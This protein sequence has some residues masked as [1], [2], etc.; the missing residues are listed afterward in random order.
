MIKTNMATDLLQVEAT[1]SELM[2]IQNTIKIGKAS[3]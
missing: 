3:L 2:H 1:H